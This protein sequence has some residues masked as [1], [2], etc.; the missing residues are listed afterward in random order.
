MTVNYYN[1]R[2]LFVVVYHTSARLYRHG[3]Q[4]IE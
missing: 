1:R 2:F 3:E 4:I